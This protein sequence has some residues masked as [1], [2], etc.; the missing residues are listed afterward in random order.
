MNFKE[1]ESAQKLRGGYYTPFDLAHYLSRWIA[2]INPV[3]VLEPSC[4]D[5]I[6]L[7][8]LSSALSV[9]SLITA[10]ELDPTEANLATARA[11]TINNLDINVKCADFLEWYLTSDQAKSQYDAIV[12]NPPFI[13]YQYLS[14]RD[15]G[16]SERIFKLHNLRFTKHTNAWV[17]FVIASLSL[18]RPS[19]RLA[20]VL[21]AEILHVLHAQ[22][23]RFY[24]GQQCKKL[25][26]I[27]PEEIWF[28]GTLQ[29]AVLLL[30]E[31]KKDIK[32][33]TAGLGIIQTRGKSFL[34]VSPNQYFNKTNFI[35]GKTVEGKW[36]RAL[37]TKKELE[38]FEGVIKGD[39]VHR[40]SDIA[41]VDVGLVTGANKF[42][43]VNDNTVNH[44][45]L[46][47]WSHPMFGRSEHCPGILYD[48]N[49][50]S[51]NSESG[52][53]SNFLWFNVSNISE[54]SKSALEYIR[55][56]EREN[57]HVRYKC[58]I[59]K[60]WFKVPS[61][62]ATQVGMLKRAHDMPRLILN[63]IRAYTTDTAY[64]ITTKNVNP[65]KLVY[66]FI[67]SLTALSSELEGRHYG[68]GVLELVPSEI[69]KLYIPIPAQTSEAI[70]ELDKMIRSSSSNEILSHQ[71][72]IILRDLGLNTDE[73]TSLHEAW[74]KL[75]NR[76]Q[77]TTSTINQ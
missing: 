49:Q 11:S 55:S 58:R 73:I 45:D 67:N 61:V 40:F 51:R 34:N 37:L 76:R 65:K 10:I 18:L 19:G 21:P 64:R 39:A 46:E 35:N 53:P 17:P 66:C 63:E 25:I 33:Y 44:Y 56:G 26:I 9:R 69:E 28:D 23:L 57:L 30:A 2:E 29:G 15:Q 24:L 5:G 16:F 8:S 1:N 12:G 36:T 13:R 70:K 50:H 47:K 42:F 7:E 27:D 6:F 48:A 52:L 74:N 68:G 54:L 60:S 20:M 4:G 32:E 71:D 59:R 38:I 22:S 62:Y 31:K 14:Q 75:R 41:D 43:L 77:R 3:T 72:N